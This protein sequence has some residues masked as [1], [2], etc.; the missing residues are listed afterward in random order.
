[1]PPS[2][3]PELEFLDSSTLVYFVPLA[4]NF[5]VENVLLSAG[6]NVPSALDGIEHRS[7][8]FFG[9]ADNAYPRD[10]LLTLLIIDT[11]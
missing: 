6:G 11:R 4:T 8:L 3:P 10:Q 7:S 1:M 9:M 2:P 5:D